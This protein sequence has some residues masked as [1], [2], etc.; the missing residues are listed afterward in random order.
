MKKR[1][2]NNSVEITASIISVIALFV[3]GV[4]S[5]LYSDKKIGCA[6][7]GVAFILGIWGIIY[8]RRS[9]K[10]FEDYVNMITAEKKGMSSDA[11]SRFPLPM[12]V[13]QINGQISWYNDLFSEMLGSSDLYNIVISDVMPDLKWSEILKSSKGVYTYAGYKGHKYNVLGDIIKNDSS[14]SDNPEYTVLLY[15][16]DKTEIESL[17]K[18]YDN[19][20]TDIAI[21]N[22]DNYDEIFQ[23]MDDSECQQTMAK[24]NK[25]ISAWVAESK[26]VMKKTERDRYIVLFEHQHLKD[27][28]QKKFDVLEK[29][30]SLGEIVKLPITVSIGVGV[31]GTIHE[32]DGYARAALDMALGRGG[33]QAAVKDSSQ[34]N[35]YG[36]IAKD[37]EKSTRVKTRAFAVA[38]KDFIANSDKV[39][40]MGHNN[41]DYDSFG[42]AIGLQRAVRAL[43]KKP[44]IVYDHSPAIKLLAEE[45]QNIEEYAGMLISP[46]EAESVITM[47]TLLVILDTHR[48]SMIPNPRLLDKT[49]KVILIDHHRRSTDFISNTSLVYHEPYA[50]STCEM[51]TEIMQYIDSGK[52][53]TAFEAKSL[54]V[55][56][57]MDTKNFTVKTGVRTFESASYLRRYGLNTS[58]VRRLFNTSKSD[59]VMR[60]EIIK[61][62]V[63]VS[64]NILISIADKE[65]QNMKVISSQAADEMLNL[66]GIRAAFV[67][68]PSEDGACISA[69]SLGDV[70]VQVI[71]ESLGGGGHATLAGAQLKT[72][73]LNSVFETLEK[74]ITKYLDDNRKD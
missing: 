58:D 18:Q 64:E 11:I 25:Y 43:E 20:K 7:M 42:A 67:I 15:F 68:Y 54:Y 73:D 31:G 46:E 69:R 65:D 33:D 44:Y 45:T 59:Y 63:L 6:L 5:I 34:Y 4:I 14:S 47:N 57:L 66:S 23:K 37:Y 48:P 72:H 8:S 51:A 41:L 39:I 49:T 19:E 27:Y 10:S 24:I 38:F 26:G 40:F 29:V 9:K 74:A 21:V 12:A 36:G 55:G 22:I 56:L 53:L 35:F 70:N 61:N 32:N 71:V 28:I 30:R 60:A 62:S 50:S 16:I 3:C 1:V 52:L 2:K 17:R 13:L